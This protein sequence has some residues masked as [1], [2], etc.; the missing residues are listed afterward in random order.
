[1]QTFRV[2]SQPV[3]VWTQLNQISASCHTDLLSET[4]DQANTPFTSSSWRAAEVRKR[5]EFVSLVFLWS[6]KS[7]LFFLRP[8]AK[9]SGTDRLKA[10]SIHLLCCS[11]NTLSCFFHFT[12]DTISCLISW[13]LHGFIQFLRG[14]TRKHDAETLSWH[15][16]D[17]EELQDRR[18]PLL[19]PPPLCTASADMLCCGWTDKL[20]CINIIWP[21][22]RK[23]A[24]STAANI[25][26][27]TLQLL[28]A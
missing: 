22:K 24:N 25:S 4:R 15:L 16:A 6:L 10:P 9:Q 23:C 1:M 27:S 20:T 2:W 19:S 13:E 12:H 14:A 21:E 26:A 17:K 28:H 11:T 7:S 5:S 18:V 8:S 3:C